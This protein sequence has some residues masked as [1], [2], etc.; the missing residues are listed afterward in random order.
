MEIMKMQSEQKAGIYGCDAQEVLGDDLSVVDTHIDLVKAGTSKDNTSANV[1]TFLNAWRTVGRGGRYKDYDFTIKVD[2]DTVLV[3][4][5]LRLRLDGLR[6]NKFIPNCDLRDRW[7]DSPDYP[8][9]LGSIEILSREAVGT[10]LAGE[11]RCQRELPWQELGEDLFL[12]KCLALLGAE[13]AGDW[14]LL[15][16][17]NCRGVDCRAFDSAAFHPFKSA[18]EWLDCWGMAVNR[19][20]VR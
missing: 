18:E 14:S 16:D 9:M 19:G 6:G 10:F 11:E 8:M 1:G 2:P 5:R 12:H 17:A 4:H 3:A 20:A 15:Q 7:P 13:Q